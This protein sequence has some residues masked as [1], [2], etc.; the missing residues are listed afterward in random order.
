MLVHELPLFIIQLKIVW[1]H[2]ISWQSMI[3]LQNEK[4]TW[5]SFPGS[6]IVFLYLLYWSLFILLGLFAFLWWLFQCIKAWELLLSFCNSTKWNK[7]LR[8][9]VKF[10]RSGIKSPSWFFFSGLI[11]LSGL[12]LLLHLVRLCIHGGSRLETLICTCHRMLLHHHVRV[13]H[14]RSKS[15]MSHL[16]VH[17]VDSL[18]HLLL[19][20]HELLTRWAHIWLSLKHLTLAHHK[21]L[22]LHLIVLIILHLLWCAIVHL[23]L[24]AHMLHVVLLLILIL[25]LLRAVLLLLLIWIEWIVEAI[26]IECVLLE[27]ICHAY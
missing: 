16:L 15:H 10:A 3:L 18:R 19:L 17:H 5:L 24:H 13:A 20:H 1:I 6:W 2:W 14:L 11:R 22:L 4:A 21:L 9:E 8:S 26:K 7:F 23:T 25:H 27:I 12:L